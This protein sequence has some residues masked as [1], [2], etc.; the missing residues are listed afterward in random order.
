MR[1]RL[2]IFDF[3]GTLADSFPWFVGAIDALAGRYRFRRIDPGEVEALRGL[4]A[5]RIL[6][7]LRIAP[8]KVRLVAAALR[9][10]MA[11][12]AE[13]IAL[14]PGIA[15]LLA[16]LAADGIAVAIV[17][18][19]SEANVRRVLG[20]ALASTVAFYGCG[21]S[22]L[23]KRPRLRAARRA[24][25]VAAHEALCVGDEIRDLEASHA[26]EMPFA[27]VAWG[28]TRADALAAHAP[29]ALVRTVPELAAALRAPRRTLR[30]PPTGCIPRC[31]SLPSPP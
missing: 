3:D 31:R 16:Q 23:G 30:P 13:S 22:V 20:P 10:R 17:S 2:A 29:S 24:T 5:S 21:A 27:A 19:N 26:E 1:Y 7:H 25:G 12:E 15:G 6:R 14:F 4:H 8:W 11:A 9:R 28:F 18:S